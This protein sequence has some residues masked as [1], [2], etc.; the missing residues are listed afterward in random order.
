MIK[1]QNYKALVFHIA[2]FQFMFSAFFW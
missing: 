1:D 2:I